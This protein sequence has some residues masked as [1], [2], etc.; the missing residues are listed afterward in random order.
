M[1]K[2]LK[3]GKM[4]R[5]LTET[6]L[7]GGFVMA[8]GGV[9]LAAGG[10]GHE[11][12]LNWWDF[13]LRS[14]NF[15]ILVAILYKLLKKPIAS[16]FSSRQ[17]SIQAKLAELESKKLEAEKVAA[18]YRAKM[19]TLEGETDKIIAELVAEGEAE[20]DKII[21]AARRQADY[22]RQQAELAI[23]QEVK[24]AKES[25]QQEVA[26]MSVQAAEELL[27]KHMQA[28]DQGRLIQEFLSRVEEAGRSQGKPS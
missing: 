10:G 20:K 22:L 23:Q 11:G 6:F 26:E 28:E 15:V 14:L 5:R 7:A 3:G 9:A 21:A 12:G 17:E 1:P 25:L 24:L 27:R 18:E 13:F 2:A 4:K 19:A 8:F 16:F